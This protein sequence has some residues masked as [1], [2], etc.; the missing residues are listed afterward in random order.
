MAPK[1]DHQGDVVG[2]HVGEF[3]DEH[4]DKAR[5]MRPFVGGEAPGGD[6]LL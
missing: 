2:G 3:W 6:D 4:G 5:A 1:V